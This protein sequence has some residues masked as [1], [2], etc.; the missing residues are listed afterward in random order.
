MENNIT[1]SF[2]RC[3][4][5]YFLTARQYP[6]LLAAIA[7][8]VRPDVY[9]QYSIHNIYYDTP[10]FRLI[11]ASIEKPVY[12][13]KLRVRSYVVPG[14]TDSVFVELKK[15]FDGVVYKRRTVM[16]EYLVEPFLCGLVPGGRYGQIGREIAWFQNT[17]RAVPKAYIGYKRTAFAGIADE[18]LRITFD[19]DLRWRDRDL[20]LCKGEHGALLLLPE[21][22][23]LMEIKLPGVCP[24][25][26]SR[27]LS[28]NE[29]F[30]TSFSKYG[31]CYQKY[32]LPAWE[33][34]MKKTEAF[35][36]A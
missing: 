1:T 3:E 4:K 11:R 21:D 22:Q 36:C 26:L 33:A 29:L 23:I 18:E 31:A 25:W 32:L 8:Y 30:P 6:H 16:P 27:V 34:K 15:K 5:K 2:Q 17:Y 35:Y 13:E 7:P 14:E 9:G 24:L 20:D 28:E 19:T 10:D 12:K